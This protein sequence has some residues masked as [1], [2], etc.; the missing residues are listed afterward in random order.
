MAYEEKDGFPTQGLHPLFSWAMVCFRVPNL[1][2][3]TSALGRA[4]ML[5]RQLRRAGM[6]RIAV[7]RG[8]TS[9][10]WGLVADA[11]DAVRP[12]AAVGERPVSG[13]LSAERIVER[14]LDVVLSKHRAIVSEEFA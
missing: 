12:R 11:E 14:K 9:R 3:A 5:G 8:S 4:L 7:G 13:R 6:L 2:A 10:H 1:A